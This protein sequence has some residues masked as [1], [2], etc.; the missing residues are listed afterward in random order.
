MKEPYGFN[1][2]IGWN[3]WTQRQIQQTSN[4]IT[5]LLDPSYN[6]VILSNYC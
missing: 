5:A 3:R 1:D 2:R 6:L 4:T